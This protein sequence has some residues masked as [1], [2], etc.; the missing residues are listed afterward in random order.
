MDVLN[1][2]DIVRHNIIFSKE[3]PCVALL[4]THFK[5]LHAVLLALIL[6]YSKTACC[7]KNIQTALVYSRLGLSLGKS[8]PRTIIR[9]SSSSSPEPSSRTSRDPGADSDFTG[10]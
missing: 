2:D 4:V 7:E 9:P 8:S 6:D 3:N 5:Y 10:M 1:H